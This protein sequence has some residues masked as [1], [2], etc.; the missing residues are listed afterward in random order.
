MPAIRWT[1][2]FYAPFDDFVL[3]ADHYVSSI[4]SWMETVR[5]TQAMKAYKKQNLLRLNI[6]AGLNKKI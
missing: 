1:V 2:A 6:N 4:A 3:N 5:T